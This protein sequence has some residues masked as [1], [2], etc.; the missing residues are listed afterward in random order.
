MSIKSSDSAA[1]ATGARQTMM[2]RAKR[3]DSFE[4]LSEACKIPLRNLTAEGGAFPYA[5]LAPPQEGAFEIPSPERLLC[6]IGDTFYALQPLP[7]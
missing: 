5:A 1:R 3:I 6:E 4:E 2:T 7:G